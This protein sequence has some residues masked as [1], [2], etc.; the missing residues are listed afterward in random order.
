MVYGFM[1]LIWP[2]MH[3]RGAQ[4][5]LT[6]TLHIVFA[7]VTVLL[8]M[9]AIGFAAAAF[10]PRFRRYSMATMLVLVV[11]GAL[12]AADGPQ[13]AAHQPTPWIGVWE[14][15]SIGAFLLWVVVLAGAILRNPRTWLVL[16]RPRSDGAQGVLGPTPAGFRP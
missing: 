11:F 4:P 14:R 16:K 12:T 6:D 15:I 9:L 1:G 13:I 3:L 7:I 2:P 5:S 10:G 8:M